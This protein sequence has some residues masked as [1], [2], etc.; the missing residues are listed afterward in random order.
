MAD[1]FH[2]TSP[3]PERSDQISEL[4]AVLFERRGGPPAFCFVV[5]AGGS[6]KTFLTNRLGEEVASRIP[7][8]AGEDAGLPVAHF[9]DNKRWGMDRWEGHVDRFPSIQ[10]CQMHFL[11]E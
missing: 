3:G 1:I 8:G 4:A 6:G 5:G 10:D 9:D 11:R 2:T 7:P